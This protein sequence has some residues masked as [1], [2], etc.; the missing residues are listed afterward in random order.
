MAAFDEGYIK[1]NRGKT[2]DFS[3]SIIIATTNAGHTNQKQNTLGFNSSD[4]NE[5]AS[6]Q[7]TVS[8]L[9]RYFDTELLN[10]FKE[11]ITFQSMTK[12]VYREIVQNIYQTEKTRLM[13]DQ[14]KLQLPDV[15]S[16]DEMDEI[17]RK[18][19]VPEFGARPAAKVVEDYIENHV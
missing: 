16:D 4:T 8:T 6:V 2:V 10:R 18:T 19:Y 3:K 11:I 1:T 15:I 9:S 12:D 14:P 5:P 7:E 13:S 17:V